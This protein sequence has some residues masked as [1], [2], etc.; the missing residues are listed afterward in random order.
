MLGATI[1]FVALPHEAEAYCVIKGTIPPAMSVPL[2]SH[3][4]AESYFVVSGTGQLLTERGGRLEWLDVKAGDFI[5]IPGGAK[6]A[7]RN[8]SN[9]P[10]V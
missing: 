8:N 4:D 5:Y 3:P 1:E 7:H 6:H 9:E 10:L 2:H